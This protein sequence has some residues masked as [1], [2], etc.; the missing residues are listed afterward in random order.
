MLL[1]LASVLNTLT[2]ITSADKAGW[3]RWRALELM[4]WMVMLVIDFFLWIA[5]L[6]HVHILAPVSFDNIGLHLPIKRMEESAPIMTSQNS[7]SPLG[8]ALTQVLALMNETP[9]S[10]E[11]YEFA[12][13]LADKIIQQNLALGDIT[14]R[15]VNKLALAAGFSRTVK[16]LTFSL[17]GLQL[18][19]QGTHWLWNLIHSIF[20][21]RLAISSQVFSVE[22]VC[23]SISNF[24]FPVQSAKCSTQLPMRP[25][26]RAGSAINCEVAEKL[27]QELLWMTKKL[28]ACSAIDEAYMKWGTL[29]C[30]AGLSLDAHP[31]VQAS[32][33]QISVLLFKEL[34]HDVEKSRRS[35]KTMLLLLWLPLF[36]CAKSGFDCPIFTASDKAEILG[37][38]EENI[39]SLSDSE[40]EMVLACWLKEYISSSSEWPNLQ[41]CFE[42]WCH[43]STK[44]ARICVD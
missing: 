25:V 31:R 27:A 8:R 21:R 10:S 39:L 3:E 2:F 44:A 41:K 33:L 24:M 38:L 16:L 20:L 37:V 30:L 15:E 6:L 5:H 28:K 11:K 34:A 14:S 9:A 29:S 7:D 40:Q 1:S 19:Q 18:Q 4:R 22:N 42:T 35:L 26:T 13:S 36:C 17:E 32:L 12:R 23:S 43:A